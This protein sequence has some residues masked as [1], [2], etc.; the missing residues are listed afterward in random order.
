MDVRG[1]GQQGAGW[2]EARNPGGM[3]RWGTTGVDR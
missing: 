1:D 3:E 2:G